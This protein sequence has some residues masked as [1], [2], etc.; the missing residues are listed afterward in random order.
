MKP[1]VL[2]MNGFITYKGREV[3]DFRNFEQGSLF[4]IS[5]PTGA[6]K[7]T[8][9]DAICFA[10]YGKISSQDRGDGEELRSQY[11]S[12]EDPKTYV[13]L[14]FEVNMQKIRIVRYPRQVIK[15]KRGSVAAV[16]EEVELYYEDKVITAKREADEKIV[17]LT[18]LTWEQFTKIVLLPQGEFRKFLTA[19]SNE[20]EE[21]LRK[22]FDTSRYQRFSEEIK[23]RYSLVQ[24]KFEILEQR[25]DL[26]VST[27]EEETLEKIRDYR[28]DD[29]LPPQ[30]Y[31]EVSDRLEEEREDLDRQLRK[32]QKK[33]KEE[34]KRSEQQAVSI[35]RAQE[36]NEKLEDYEAARKELSELCEHEEKIA[37]LRKR[38]DTAR[39]SSILLLGEQEVRRQ[40][41]VLQK[42]D[43]DLALLKTAEGEL[44]EKKKEVQKDYDG[45]ES[46]EEET[47]N[48]LHQIEALKKEIEELARLEEKLKEEA[49]YRKKKKGGEGVVQRLG[50]ELSTLEEEIAALSSPLKRIHAKTTEL[51]ELERTCN[52]STSGLEVLR[53]IYKH[54]NSTLKEKQGLHS[55]TQEVPK[56]EAELK[57][58]EEELHIKTEN[59][60]KQLLLVYAET[61]KEGEACP[62]CGSLHHP[63][64]LE[65]G[66]VVGK[67]ELEE[68]RKA[69]TELRK[70]LVQTQQ[71][72]VGHRANIGN[73]SEELR[74]EVGRL[75]NGEAGALSRR[76]KSLTD[77]LSVDEEEVALLVEESKQAGSEL[78]KKLKGQEESLAQ[79]RR[80]LEIL[81]DEAKK[82]EELSKQREELLEKKTK[83][84]K[85]LLLYAEKETVCQVEIARIMGELRLETY[86]VSEGE[87]RRR[88]LAKLQDLRSSNKARIAQIKKD[89]QLVSDKLHL[90]SGQLS[91]LSEKKVEEELRYHQSLSKWEKDVAEIFS[92][93]E[94][95]R[96]SL[97][98]EEEMEEDESL[99]QGY[100]KLKQ[101]LSAK[102]QTLSAQLESKE[103]ADV[104]ALEEEK[105]TTDQQLGLLREELK[106]LSAKRENLS[107]VV[108][109]MKAVIEEQGREGEVRRRLAILNRLCSGE[110]AVK[111]TL[112][113]YVLMYYFEEVL[114]HANRRLYQMTDGQY[115]LYRKEDNFK[116][117]RRNKGLELEILDANVGKKRNTATLSGGEGFLA[118]LSL[119][120]GLSDA[121][122]SATG[123]IEVHT[124]F[125]DEGFG[126]LDRDKLQNAIDCL[127]ELTGK[128]RLIGIISHVEELKQDIPNK[129]LVDYK[130]DSGSSLK[131]VY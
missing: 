85:D 108:E 128:H 87:L 81:G 13:E 8:I 103:K 99:I 14:E 98:S 102:L 63:K 131:M 37:T 19:A 114:A 21:I 48:L 36:H 86:D 23:R 67:Q 27:L 78:K 62:L 24:K 61:L 77:L 39:R 49:L 113:T 92:S 10:L 35:H 127:L 96:Q 11:L 110:N 119:A 16:S 120:L 97:M 79:G 90:I 55:L 95:Y 116:G 50:T 42:T 64:V 130:K 100:E 25:V 5:G 125:I 84:E 57:Q 93:P 28:K 41:E 30:F 89:Y 101:E 122:M 26:A 106:G 47:E 72:E 68:E 2:T 43:S 109:V 53:K 111:A 58:R 56:L 22:I 115:T 88:E 31:A 18:G 33:E 117:N 66:E 104:N 17:E 71:K 82:E 121:M 80:E 1:I 91:S 40:K 65:A 54:L 69:I 44:A 105:K 52:T 94:E 4:I 6:G 70:K 83:A 34:E 73:L 9:F 123:Q 38:L 74:E 12:P 129:I 51:I 107:K 29:R 124:L 46:L 32:G 15:K 126:T 75:G 3:V 112:E 7:T 118:S 45:I 59:F 76:L 20:K 60:E